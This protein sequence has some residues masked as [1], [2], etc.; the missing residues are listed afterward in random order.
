MRVS[1]TAN[2]L[3]LISGKSESVRKPCAIVVPKGPD[4]A[5]SR[6][7]CIHWWSPVASANSWMRSCVTSIQSLT[8]SSSPTRCFNS[9]SVAKLLIS[10]VHPDD[11]RCPLL[12]V[13]LEA[14]GGDVP[15]RQAVRRQ[16]HV[17]LRVTQE[18]EQGHAHR[19]EEVAQ[20]VGGDRAFARSRA[21]DRE[22]DVRAAPV[23]EQLLD[24]FVRRVDVED[25]RLQRNEHLV[26]QPHHFVETLAVQ[27]RGRV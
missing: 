22:L 25:A 24:E 18:P 19:I 11:D 6:S 5:R 16:V 1:L 17:V 4:R 13:A 8:P 15:E 26:G 23:R 27:A 7:R 14:H 3:A 10:S 21:D 20:L 12:A 9:A 2:A